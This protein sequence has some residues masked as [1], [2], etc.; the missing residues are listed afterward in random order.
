[1]TTQEEIFDSPTGWV[2]DHIQQYV[3]SDGEKGHKWRGIPT[4]LL[5]TRGRKSG[6]LRRTAL[7]YGQ[8]DGNYLI[9]ASKGGADDHP[10]WY[11]NLTANPA[12]AIQVGAE[13]F[14]G[15]ARTA[16][17]AEKPRLWQIMSKIFPTYD[18]YQVRAGKVG[19][20]IP[21]VIIEPI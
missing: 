8:A 21:L 19:R 17:A 6:K 13:K 14:T 5:T 12:V 1:M 11:L 10:L 3:E 7:I 9:V 20:E 4:L 16:N 15:R 18:A 2:R